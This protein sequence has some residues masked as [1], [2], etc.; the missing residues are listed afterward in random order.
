M[1]LDNTTSVTSAAA[2]CPVEAMV[3]D[4]FKNLNFE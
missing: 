3:R 2:V 4:T 1:E